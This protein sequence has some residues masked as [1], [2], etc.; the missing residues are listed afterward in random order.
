MDVYHYIIEA[1]EENKTLKTVESI[2][3]FL[4]QNKVNRNDVLVALGGGVIGDVTGYIAATYLRGIDFIQI[5]TTLLSQVD[6]SI[7]GKTG[8][9][10]NG[11]KNMIGAFHMPKLVYTNLSTLVSLEERQFYSG[12]AE[13]MKAALIGDAVLYEWLITNMYEICDRD[14]CV[15]SVIRNV[16][17]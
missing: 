3:E 16:L 13:V 1:G 7:G 15:F 8:V 12:F 5:P 4:I 14:S 17:I 9:D 10:F 6:S 11:Y 2:Y